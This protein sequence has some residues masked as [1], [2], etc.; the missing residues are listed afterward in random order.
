MTRMFARNRI[1]GDVFGLKRVQ[2]VLL[3]GLVVALRLY[4]FLLVLGR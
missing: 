3:A 4:Q 1:N 2:L